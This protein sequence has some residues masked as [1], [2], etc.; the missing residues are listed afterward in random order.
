MG[1]IFR[2]SVV[3]SLLLCGCAVT[4]KKGNETMTLR[5]WGAKKAVFSDNSSIEKEEP[6]RIPDIVYER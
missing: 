3:L 6:I 4:A 2:I 1:I 5:G